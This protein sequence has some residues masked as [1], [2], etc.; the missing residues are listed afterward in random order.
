MA[1]EAGGGRQ[2]RCPSSAGI[3]ALWS[4]VP[5]LTLAGGVREGRGGRSCVTGP[6][7]SRRCA[8]YIFQR[9][10]LSLL[11]AAAQP[12]LQAY[13]WAG[14][15][16]VAATAAQRRPT[17]LAMR[18]AADAARR[19]APLF[20]VGRWAR[21]FE[22]SVRAAWEGFAAGRAVHTMAAIPQPT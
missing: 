8:A 15:E 14:Y 17:W 16:L 5:L 12:Q 10:A 3:D 18:R 9:N 20:D 2:R 11:A 19:S 4:G 22:A 6:G 7:G 1:R 13:S 21:G